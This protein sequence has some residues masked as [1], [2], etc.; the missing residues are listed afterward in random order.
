MFFRRFFFLLVFFLTFILSPSQT[1]AIGISPALVEINDV[2]AGSMAKGEIFVSRGDASQVEKI[3]VTITGSSASYIKLVKGDVMELP[4]A[5]QVTSIPFVIEPK[6]LATGNYQAFMVIAPYTEDASSQGG[7]GSKV[8][9]GASSP[10][11]TA[12]TTSSRT[13]PCTY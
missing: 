8:L 5:E 2:L 6:T 7:S 1:Y 4:Q 3:S 11:S 13:T 10:P 9:S 12:S